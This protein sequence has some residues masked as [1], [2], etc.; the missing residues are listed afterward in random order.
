M[1]DIAGGNRD[2][3]ES[4]PQIG[5]APGS[6]FI[7]TQLGKR[8]LSASSADDDGAH[9]SPPSSRISP[10][11]VAR[12]IA[13]LSASGTTT[14]STAFRSPADA[15]PQDQDQQQQARRPMC[16]HG[17]IGTLVRPRVRRVP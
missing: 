11:D 2:D 13:S 14:T 17:R 10:G 5:T 6:A 12:V 8:R 3:G 16:Q 7:P 4:G 9:D 1:D 15:D